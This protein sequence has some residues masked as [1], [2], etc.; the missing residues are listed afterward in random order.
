M[1]DDPAGHDDV[2]VDPP[3]AKKL[4]PPVIVMKNVRRRPRPLPPA[5]HSH[6][7]AQVKKYYSLA[8]REDTVK[9]LDGITLAAGSEFYPIRKGEF[10]ML[11][12][13]SGGGKTTILNIVG[14]LRRRRR[15]LFWHHPSLTS[16]GTIDRATEGEVEILGRR[17][18]AKCSD[19]DLAHT[20]LHQIGFVFQTFNLL[21]TMS[22]FENVELPMTIRNQLSRKE[23]KNKARELLRLVGL[24]DREM[25]LPSELSGGEQQRVTIARA[26]SNDPDVLL[27]GNGF[28]FVFFGQQQQAL[29][30]VADEPTGDLDTR[31]TVQVMDLLLRINQELGITMLMVSH[32]PDLETYAD[33]VL[34]I[35]N[36]VLESQA[37]NA[38]QTKLDYD[39]YVRYLNTQTADAK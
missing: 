13:P 3:I 29:T 17:I 36:G 2:L 34:Y 18:D 9:A 5:A 20:R 6:P 12:G 38:V 21:A 39:A 7:R 31:N 37:L 32:N 10:V 35:R 26:L 25:H 24:R 4:G 27:L 15:R 14:A 22:A 19:A 33:R 8:G 30:H 23:R 28:V 1:E 16:P 11:R